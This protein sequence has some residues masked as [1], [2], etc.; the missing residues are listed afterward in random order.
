MPA[1]TRRA[2]LE[3]VLLEQRPLGRRRVYDAP[4]ALQNHGEL[5]PRAASIEQPQNALGIRLQLSRE[6][7]VG[8]GDV[9]GAIADYDEAIRL[10][11]EDAYACFNRGV[12]RKELGDVA[13]AIADYD[14]AIRLRPEYASAYYNRASIRRA[15]KEHS[16]AL[17]DYQKLLDLGGGVRDGDQK[18][19]EG[20]IRELKLQLSPPK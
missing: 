15:Q 17:A 7:L 10:N 5:I 19:V 1:S 3:P 11:P 16:Y 13:G 8:R 2:A 12:A 14:E 18:K 6:R 4:A 20:F 9:A